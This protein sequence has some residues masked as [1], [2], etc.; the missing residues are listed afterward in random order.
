MGVITVAAVQAA[1]LPVAGLPIFGQSATL[2][3]FATDTERV[4]PRSPGPP[5]WC[6]PSC[7]CSAPT[8]NLSRLMISCSRRPHSPFTAS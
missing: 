4:R 5:Y 7:T 8:T 6:I 2:D 1:P 3:A